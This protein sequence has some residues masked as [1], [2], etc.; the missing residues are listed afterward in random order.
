MFGRIFNITASWLQ[1]DSGSANQLVY[2]NASILDTV[3]DHL[4]RVT[5]RRTDGRT[6]EL[7]KIDVLYL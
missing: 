5:A 1:T 6:S 2:W 3:S 7:G 4:F